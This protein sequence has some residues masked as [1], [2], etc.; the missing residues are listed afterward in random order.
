MLWKIIQYS[1]VSVSFMF[2]CAHLN[3]L[4]QSFDIYMANVCHIVVFVVAEYFW[5]P[6]TYM[7]RHWICNILILILKQHSLVT[8]C[9]NFFTITI[10]LFLWKGDFE[11][12]RSTKKRIGPSTR[13]YVHNF[14]R[15]RTWF[16]LPGASRLA[17][18][19][20]TPLVRSLANTV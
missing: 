5:L 19:S 16:D 14:G 12:E 17:Y 11:F 18:F 7:S 10:C 1:P 15:P 6:L 20:I 8:E 3:V 4:V 13:F 2:I 9:N